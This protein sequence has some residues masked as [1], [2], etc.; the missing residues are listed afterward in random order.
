MKKIKSYSII[1]CGIIL[2]AAGISLFYLPNK[3]VT[4]GVSGVSTMLY[5]VFEIPASLSLGI[6][7]VLLLII[8]L[9]ILGKEFTLKTLAV[10]LLLSLFVDLFERM[11]RVTD[12]VLLA[13]VF[14]AVI[15]GFGIGLTLIEG[16]S[17][18][19]TDILGRILQHYFPH[20]SIGKALLFTDA[21]IIL[22]SLIVFGNIELTMYG[23]IGLF[24][25]T[26]AIDTLIKY[27][28]VSKLVFVIT[29]KGDKICEY[30]TGTSP[31]GV[32]VLDVVGGYTGDKKNMLMCAMKENEL[33]AFQKK[34]LSFDENAFIIFTESQ[35][36]VGNGFRVY[37]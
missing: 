34:V 29:D 6:I 17:T 13:T 5:H 32:T 23:I 21:G 28:N 25:S 11:P 27:L 20:I 24:I 18:G 35:Q 14:G 22:T 33:H 15:F 31:R 8:G 10:S 36:I 3:I 7:N 19:G 2:T 12:N 1:L 26:L 37:K 9:K 16:A 30:L 4:G